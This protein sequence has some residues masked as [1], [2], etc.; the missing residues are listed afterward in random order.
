MPPPLFAT[1]AL[2]IALIAVAPAR[3]TESP[4]AAVQTLLP[5]EGG[6]TV[7]VWADRLGTRAARVY[8]RGGSSSYGDFGVPFEAGLVASCSTGTLELDDAGILTCGGQRPRVTPAVTLPSDPSAFATSP[9]PPVKAGPRAVGSV[10]RP[11]LPGLVPSLVGA[12][13]L[14]LVALLLSRLRP[15]APETKADPPLALSR[16]VRLSL[17]GIIIVGAGLRL[18]NLGLEPLE[19]NEFTYVMTAFGHDSGLDVLLDVNAM[20]QTHAPLP[21]L[22]QYALSPLGTAEW[23]TRLPMAAAGILTLPV[24]FLLGWR[25]GRRTFG[26]AHAAPVALIATALLAASPVHVWYSRDASPYALVTLF[27]ALALLGAE[28]ATRGRG[29]RVLLAGASVLGFYTHYYALHLTLVL[30]ALVLIGD[31]L[32]GGLRA[33]LPTLASGLAAAAALLPWLPAF[34]AAFQW[35]EGH[36]TAYQRD[37]GVYHPSASV[38]TD[39]LDVVRLLLGLGLPGAFAVGASMAAVLGVALLRDRARI[40]AILLLA[41]PIAW[42]AAFELVNRETFLKSLYGGYYFGIRYGLFLFPGAVLLVA[43]ALRSLPGSHIGRA[44]SAATLALLLGDAARQSA[45]MPFTAKKPDVASAAVLVTRHARDGDAIL[46]G[47]AVFYQHPWHYYAAPPERR[48]AQRA[49]DWMRT[50]DWDTSGVLGVLTDLVEPWS[51]SL[52]SAFVKRVWV[53]DH[54]QHLFGRREFSDRPAAAIDAALA[55]APGGFTEVWRRDLHD[56]RVRLFERTSAVLAPLPTAPDGRPGLHM[57]WN[58]GPFIRGTDP[59]TAWTRPGRR[60]RARTELQLPVPSGALTLTLRAGAVPVGPPLLA[61]TGPA[62][63]VTFQ[64]VLN[65][66]TVGPWTVTADF[67]TVDIPLLPADRGGVHLRFELGTRPAGLLPSDLMLDWVAF[68]PAP[69]TRG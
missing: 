52:S 47:P 1:A 37:A 26:D 42:F 58:D 69:T 10:S 12:A 30:Y 33:T 20:A 67:D 48:D 56:V 66:R 3:A 13:V 38:V 63:P 19:Q 16:V 11:R 54:T 55:N 53:V 49:G 36:S 65:G 32:R 50:P 8:P 40:G 23:V 14:A 25:F 64:V 21:H 45:A 60:V 44:L 6:P 61:P 22:I 43:L 34:L 62:T 2:L 29:G 4:S 18:W 17:A 31:I 5:L 68:T 39:G 24:L 15:Q 59:S 7:P 35:S 9:V 27:A 57:G 46:V 41:A 28:R 51:R